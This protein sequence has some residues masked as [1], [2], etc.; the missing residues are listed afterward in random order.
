MFRLMVAKDKDNKVIP[1][2]VS[3]YEQAIKFFLPVSV[4]TAIDI[5][6]KKADKDLFDE[7]MKQALPVDVTV[8]DITLCDDNCDDFICSFVDDLKYTDFVALNELVNVWYDN[9]VK[10]RCDISCEDK[11]TV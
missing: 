2:C 4:D 7:V 5:A 6:L 8:A 10:E 9:F 1:F 3:S 11:K